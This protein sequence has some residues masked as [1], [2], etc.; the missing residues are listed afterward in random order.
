[1]PIP[2]AYRLGS[3]IGHVQAIEIWNKPNLGRE[4]GGQPISARSAAEYV[5]LL[6]GA[7]AAAKATYTAVQSACQNGSL[8][9]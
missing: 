4:W 7:Y 8:P 1:M 2:S 6:S 3:S 5:R 9:R